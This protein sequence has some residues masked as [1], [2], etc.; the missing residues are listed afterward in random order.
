MTYTSRE[1]K[2]TASVVMRDAEGMGT[3]QFAKY[4]LSHSILMADRDTVVT[5]LELL[6]RKVVK[7][8]LTSIEMEANA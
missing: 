5:A 6:A 1:K 8:E 4:C 7:E 2:L 3:E